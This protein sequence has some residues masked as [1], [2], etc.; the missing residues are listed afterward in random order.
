MANPTDRALLVF[1]LDT[2]GTMS[3]KDRVG[4]DVPVASIEL[5]GLGEFVDIVG[6]GFAMELEGGGDVV[7]DKV[8]RKSTGAKVTG[9][10]S[11]GAKVTGA[12]SAGAKVT[13]AMSAGAEAT[14][15]MSAG[16]E[17]TGATS[18]GAKVTGASPS[19]ANVTGAGTSA[20][21][22]ERVGES[23]LVTGAGVV[24]GAGV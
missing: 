3:R 1:A 12:I 23:G 10:I 20:V 7:G 9:A 18:A 16:A 11:A 19:G 14:G 8:V 21:A 15:A 22:G 5:E 2:D 6:T 17:V 4:D 13:G 24:D